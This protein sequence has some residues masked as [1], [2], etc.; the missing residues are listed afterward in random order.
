MF[1]KKKVNAECPHGHNHEATENHEFQHSHHHRSSWRNK[2]LAAVEFPLAIYTGSFALTVAAGHNAVDGGVHNLRDLASAETNAYLRAKQRLKAAGLLG[3]A[4][5]ASFIFDKL[6]GTHTQ[7]PQW[8]GWVFAGETAVNVVG[9]VDGLQ[10]GEEGTDTFTSILHNGTDALVSAMTSA[11]ILVPTYLGEKNTQLL[12][13]LAGYGH[14]GF[15][16]LVATV[17]AA[18]AFRD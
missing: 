12:D 11:T 8:V 10:N 1:L 17:T 9:L 18:T 5:V 4:G 7:I 2:I 3:A 13:D 6:T 15:M 14:L 16:G